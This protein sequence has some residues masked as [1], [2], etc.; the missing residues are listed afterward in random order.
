MPFSFRRDSDTRPSQKSSHMAPCFFRSIR[1]PTLR[2]FSSVTYVVAGTMP[3]RQPALA[4]FQPFV[5]EICSRE[6]HHGTEGPGP[7]SSWTGIE[8]RLSLAAE[9][10]GGGF[11]FGLS[12]S[13]RGHGAGEL[14]H[15]A[16]GFDLR[17]G[18]RGHDLFEAAMAV[19]TGQVVFCGHGF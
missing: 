12:F 3:S 11:G 9:G 1:T 5:D 16:V 13:E 19:M 8:V 15:F 4:T 18:E 14:G 17:F 2:P 7:L 6:K 10:A